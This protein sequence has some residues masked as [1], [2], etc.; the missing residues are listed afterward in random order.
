M[1]L[2]DIRDMYDYNCWANRRLLAMASKV[3]HEQFTAPSS[4]SY[5]TLQ[6]TLVHTLDTEW[7][8]R[9]VL[10]GEGF[11]PELKAEDF[12]T[13]SAI[14]TRWQQEEKDMWAFIDSL[15]DDDLKRVISYENDEGV[16]RKRILWQVMFHIINHGMQH[17]SE[18]ANLL[19][20][21][22]QSPGD[23][24]FTIYLN[25]LAAVN[26]TTITNRMMICGNLCGGRPVAKIAACFSR[27]FRRPHPVL[28]QSCQY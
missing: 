5:S 12:P 3:T 23:I 20:I 18:A 8:W 11:T 10:Q 14:Q 25:E 17:R 28:Q 7:G 6:R 26:L 21:Y 1:N 9:L 2:Q 19:T 15:T 22:G 24:D 16:L 13:V 4:H 27:A